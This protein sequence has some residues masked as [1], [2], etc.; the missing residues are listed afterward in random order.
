MVHL[1]YEAAALERKGIKTEKGNHNREVQRRNAERVAHKDVQQLKVEK[2]EQK[3]EDLRQIEKELQKIREHQKTVQHME[4]S[5]EIESESP[6]VSE[7]EK[8]L[9]AEKAMQHLEKMQ[10]QQNNAE[11]I[12]KR[13]NALKETSIALE[14]AKV[15]LIERHNQIKLDLPPLEYRAELL[16]EHAQNIETLQGRAAQLFEARR[17]VGLLEFK[18]KKDIDEKIAFASQELG[19][20]KDFFKNRFNVDPAQTREELERLQAEIRAKKDE[21]KAKQIRVQVIRK[22]QDSIELEYRTQKL[23]NDTRLDHEQITRLMEQM[24]QPPQSV[25]ERLLRERVERQLDVISDYYFERAIE[26]LPQHQAQILT[27]IREQAKEREELLKFERE[28][29]FLIRYYQTQDKDERK[30]L[31][32]AEDERRNQTYDR[33]R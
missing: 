3:A 14:K 16:E 32:R 26:N 13:M 19:R 28:Q 6:F 31:L 2:S 18:K 4:K 27:N 1:G 9:K 8:Q 12:A 17:N 20:A 33:S 10:E 7:L 24:R 15:S 29:A 21:L 5:F 23:L 25:R 30:R 22:K 11:Q